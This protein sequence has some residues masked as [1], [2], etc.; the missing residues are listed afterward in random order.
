M[1][2][3]GLE[4]MSHSFIKHW[5]VVA[6]I[7]WRVYSGIS[8]G[9]DWLSRDFSVI[10]RTHGQISFAPYIHG[11][12]E[13][14]NYFQGYRSDFSAYVDFFEWKGLISNWLIANSTIIEKL[15]STSFKLDR[16]RYTL[17]PGYRYEFDNWL[18]SGLLLHECIHTISK[19]ESGGSTWWNSFQFGLGSNGAYPLYLVDRYKKQDFSSQLFN[20]WDAQINFGIFL[21]G[22]QSV[23]L[24]QNHSYR[25]EL[26]SLWRFH[27][28]TW[29]KWGSY[30]DFHQHSWMKSDKTVENKYSLALTLLL[31][32]K[33][34]FASLY[35]EY[36]LHDSNSKDNEDNLGELGFKI[37][38]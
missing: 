3:T 20:H 5:F 21:Y 26:F 8:S 14:N 38:F 19:E 30:L 33:I 27:F 6:L 17:T 16:I 24:A 12:S 37:I 25:F 2:Y 7:S 32:G 13:R 36:H 23:W 1:A 10:M 29:K 9:L 4:F 34:N 35:Y 15:D 28:G 11:S 31:T 18:I 22:S